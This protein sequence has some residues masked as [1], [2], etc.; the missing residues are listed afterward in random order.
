M[1]NTRGLDRAKVLKALYDHAKRQGLGILQY[2]PGPLTI[3]E[4]E[5]LLEERDR[6]DYVGGRVLKV[7][8]K[9]PDCFCEALYDRDNGRGAARN[10]IASIIYSRPE[11]GGPGEL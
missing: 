1:I 8:L 5:K 6:F 7:D 9:N 2:T 4:A 11:N 3:E 10:A